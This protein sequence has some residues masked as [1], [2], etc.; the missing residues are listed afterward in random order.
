MLVIYTY[1]ISKTVNH[2]NLN[3]YIFLKLD[4]C[5][6]FGYKDY[7]IPLPFSC[8]RKTV[9]ILINEDDEGLHCTE[10]A[11]EGCLDL[12]ASEK[13]NFEFWKLW[14]YILD[15]LMSLQCSVLF[16]VNYCYLKSS[17]E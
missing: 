17:G 15:G 10:Y 5:G 7:K 9:T 13:D 14:F 6:K 4:C 16:G 2:P 12:V 3:K 1:K 11:E 8:C